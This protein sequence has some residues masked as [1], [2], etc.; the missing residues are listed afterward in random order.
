M[1]VHGAVLYLH[2]DHEDHHGD[3]EQGIIVI[4][5]RLDEQSDAVL[6]LYETGD[7]CSPGRDRSDDTDRSCGRVDQVCELCTGDLVLVSYGAHHAADCQTVKIVVDEDQ[8][9]EADG[10]EL[11][12]FSAGDLFRSP[13]SEC[14]TAAGAVHQLNH[15]AQD[16]QEHQ[17]AHVVGVGE[18]RNDTV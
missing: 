1:L 11:R 5:N 17:D 9:A 13:V 16:Y 18:N 8:A 15:D 4:R 14:S 12:A 10:G 6:A 7:R 3:G 2:H